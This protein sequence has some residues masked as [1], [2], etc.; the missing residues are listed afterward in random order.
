MPT[1]DTGG[2]YGCRC[3]TV[4]CLIW[5]WQITDASSLTLSALTLSAMRHL[6]EV[7]YAAMACSSGWVGGVHTVLLDMLAFHFV[8]SA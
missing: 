5:A 6:Q 8:F 2:I 7:P 4:V 3:I 1:T